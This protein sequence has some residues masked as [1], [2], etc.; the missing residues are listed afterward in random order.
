[1][2]QKLLKCGYSETELDVA[3]TSVLGLNGM[4]ILG[5]PT[6]E[7]AKSTAP[8]PP[9]LQQNSSPLTFVST[10]S[11]FTVHLKTLV[12]GLKADIKMLNGTDNIIFACRKNPNSASLLFCKSLF[13]QKKATTKTSQKFD[14]RNCK[15][16]QLMNLPKFL[17]FNDLKIKLHFSLNLMS[18]N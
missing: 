4:Q 9:T 1:M 3:R 8:L 5:L 16:C 14:S 6:P 10:Y 17:V 15:S 12:K 18:D 11:A 7:I 2:Y 13:S